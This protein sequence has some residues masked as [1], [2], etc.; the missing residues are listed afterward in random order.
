MEYLENK[1][2]YE[3]YVSL[4]SSV[5]WLNFEPEQVAGSLRNSLYDITV[6]E[7]GQTIAMGRMVGDGVYFLIV[8]VVVR[9]EY[10]RQGIG[11]RIID[12]LLA[13]VEEHTPVGGRSSVQLLSEKG[14]E[15]FYIQKGFKLL[16][17]EFCGPGM[18]KIIRK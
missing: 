2:S 5:G 12:K 3:D 8:D 10:Q 13:Y 7:S 4:R 18:R 17:H 6:E 15:A 9:P 11:S 1:L 16:P 14:K